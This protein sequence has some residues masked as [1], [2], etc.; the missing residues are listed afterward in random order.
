[1]LENSELDTVIILRTVSGVRLVLVSVEK[2]L[3]PY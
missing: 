3:K 2:R 1:M